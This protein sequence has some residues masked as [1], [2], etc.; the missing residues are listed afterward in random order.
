VIL[1]CVFAIAEAYP[2]QRDSNTSSVDLINTDFTV[3]DINL[4]EYME[5]EIG[6][7]IDGEVHVLEI[8]HG[9]YKNAV[10]I[11]TTVRNDSLLIRDFQNFNF[12]FPQDKLSAHKVIDARMRLLLPPGKSLIINTRSAVLLISG[13]FNDLYINQ[14]SGKCKVIDLTGN[15][16]FT[17]IYADVIFKAPHYR[18]DYATQRKSLT[19]KFTKQPAKFIAQIE[20]IHGGISLK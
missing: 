9:E 6:N 16:N 12:S 4:R 5:L 18:I 15:F 14:F 10:S 8:Q 1:F 19:T 7:S 13:A 17:S 11:S 3:V 20:T 2:Q